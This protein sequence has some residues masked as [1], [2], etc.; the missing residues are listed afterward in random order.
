M[1]IGRHS[2]LGTYDERFNPEV[3]IGN[4][5]SIGSGAIFYGSCEHP[6]TISTYPF[7]DKGW[8]D[9]YPKTFSRGKIIIGND[10]WIGEDV[11]IL[12]GITI[13]DG[14]IIGAGSVV[15]KNVPAYARVAGNPIKIID[16]RF[17]P[18][19]I[20]ALL[21]LKWWDKDD[22][23]IKELLPLMADPKRFM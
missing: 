19:E 14:V 20:D 6:Q 17:N 21:R 8:S 9:E 23:E 3:E 16:H 2:Y 22:E 12:D 13:G 7:G 5:T 15:S 18:F 4:F 1:K 11:R 10:V